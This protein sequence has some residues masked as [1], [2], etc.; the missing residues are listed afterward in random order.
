MTISK[1]VV[2][3]VLRERGQ[4]MR[5]EFVDRELPE[6]IDPQRH[7]GLLAMLNLE[8]SDLTEADSA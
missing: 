1:T 8:P 3:A 2:I 6:N 4:H 7:G 5:A